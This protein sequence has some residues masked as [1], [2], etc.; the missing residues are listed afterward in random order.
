MPCSPIPRAS[1]ASSVIPRRPSCK[2]PVST[3]KCSGSPPCGRSHSRGGADLAFLHDSPGDDVFTVHPRQGTLAGPG[4]LTIV[5]NFQTIVGRALAGG[6]DKAFLHDGPNDDVFATTLTTGN[7]TGPG[8]FNSAFGFGLI[9]GRSIHGGND[10]AFLFDSP[11]DDLFLGRGA[12]GTLSGL[13]F[14]NRANLFEAV[15]IFGSTGFN[16][17]VAR[18]LAYAFTRF[19]TWFEV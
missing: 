9:E 11:G 14:S 13:G 15:A 7:F 18:D 4:Y 1:I 19:G 8:Y 5:Q 2:A 16:Q 6:S 17:L 12:N 3:C 10:R